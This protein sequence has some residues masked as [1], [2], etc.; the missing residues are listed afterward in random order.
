MFTS[1]R[2]KKL[3]CLMCVV[4]DIKTN[5][6][7]ILCFL[8]GKFTDADICKKDISNTCIKHIKYSIICQY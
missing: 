8:C 4:A 1:W 2:D 5:V 6:L 3:H 7:N